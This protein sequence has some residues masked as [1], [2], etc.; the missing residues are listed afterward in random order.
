MKTPVGLG[1]HQAPACLQDHKTLVSVLGHNLEKEEAE[2]WGKP[3]NLPSSGIIS[4]IQEG[5][6]VDGTLPWERA[7]TAAHRTQP[8]SQLNPP[9]N[10]PPKAK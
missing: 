2:I 3:P 1:G 7:S 10:T 4:P 9:Q 5:L 8:H 6:E